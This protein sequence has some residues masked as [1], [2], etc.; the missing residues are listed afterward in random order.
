LSR[1]FYFLKLQFKNVTYY[2]KKLCHIKDKSMGE[3][4]SKG[5]RK[6]YD[7]KTIRCAPPK[8]DLNLKSKLKKYKG[9]ANWGKKYL[10]RKV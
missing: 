8:K 1:A 3:R 4:K 10:R 2:Y 6:F 9:G 5:E 7:N